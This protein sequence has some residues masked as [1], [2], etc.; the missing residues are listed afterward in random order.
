MEEY[1]GEPA[2]DAGL[3]AAAQAV[4]HYEMSDEGDKLIGLMSGL[5]RRPVGRTQRPARPGPLPASRML[6]ETARA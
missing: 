5:R 3:L 4:E 2:L 1:K 6:P